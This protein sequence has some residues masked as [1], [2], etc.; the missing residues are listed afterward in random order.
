[1][2]IIQS[3]WKYMVSGLIAGLVLITA[4][5]VAEPF[6]RRDSAPPPSDNQLALNLYA[7]AGVVQDSNLPTNGERTEAQRDEVAIADG[8]SAES[9]EQDPLA[10]SLVDVFNTLHFFERNGEYLVSFVLPEIEEFTLL[11]NVTMVC[12]DGFSRN[13]KDSWTGA[14]AVGRIAWYAFDEIFFTI[15]DVD[16]FRIT[17][18]LTNSEIGA[19]PINVNMSRE[20]RV[21]PNDP[22]NAAIFSGMFDEGTAYDASHA[23]TDVSGEEWFNE[24]SVYGYI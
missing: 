5:S 6:L 13:L 18:S 1:M 3:Y 14:D 2:S 17:L 22:G 12:T 20:L 21:S 15:N 16:Y 23:F 8:L 19:N 9:S 11:W 4:L 24:I 10:Q 7:E